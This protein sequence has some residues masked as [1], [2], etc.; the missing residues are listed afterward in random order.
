MI[1]RA[2]STGGHEPLRPGKLIPREVLKKGKKGVQKHS[3]ERKKTSQTWICPCDEAGGGLEKKR[4]GVWGTAW[5]QI[6]KR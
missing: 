4:T 1:R 3:S 6:T 2:K 5:V